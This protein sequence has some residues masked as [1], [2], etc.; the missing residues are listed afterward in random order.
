MKAAD[1]L[2]RGLYRYTDILVRE[3]RGAL[4]WDVKGRRFL[5]FAGGIG[6]LNVGHCHPEVVAAVREQAG[7]LIH[8]CAHVAL[9]EGYLEVCARLSAAMPGRFPKKAALFN[10]GAEAVENA[11]KVA[12]RFTGRPAVIAF[13][14][15]FHGRTLLA[16]TLTGKEKPYRDGF[17]PYAPEV[18]HSPYPYP[19]RTPEG[20]PSAKAGE[21]ALD[22]LAELFHTQVDP[23]RVAAILIEPV[24]GEGGFVVPPPGFLKA[25]RALCDKHG[26]LL[27]F[28]EIQ[29]GFGRTARMFACEHSGVIPDLMTVAKSLA[30][31]MP[32]SG[33]VGR[34]EVMDAAAP[35]AIGGTYGGNPVACAAALAVFR[36]I[37]NENL[38]AA[39]ARIGARIERRFAAWAK[40]LARVGEA[41][42]LGAMRAVELVC[43]KRTKAP[44][45]AAQVQRVLAAC[46]DKG[47]IILKAGLHNNVLRTLV[48]L[49]ASDAEIDEGLD[50]LESVLRKTPAGGR[51]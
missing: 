4:C 26:I 2:P 30:A 6:V 48:P 34:A 7:R 3:A 45:P 31:G 38:C 27:V 22:R 29:T 14:L 13:D 11:V 41:R 37:E 23:A 21:Y 15:S 33:L 44:L 36:I 35:G 32:L 9:Y 49:V 19:Y 25:L 12:R 8:S 51:T 17:G 42:G 5:D 47:L 39:A 46:A 20:V 1:I 43:D 10:S 24:L 40:N 28:D 18:Y 50:I 16:L